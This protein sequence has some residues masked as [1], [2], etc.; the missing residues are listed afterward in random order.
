MQIFFLLCMTVPLHRNITYFLR[1][2]TIVDKENITL[3]LFELSS[4]FL[5]KNSSLKA[6][7][8]NIFKN[9]F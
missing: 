7:F 6:L 9:T 8:Q 5:N 3:Q 1:V 2:H 4:I